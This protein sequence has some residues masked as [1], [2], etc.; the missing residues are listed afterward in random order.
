MKK[1]LTLISIFALSGCE[2]DAWGTKDKNDTDIKK[3]Y[4]TVSEFQTKN[5]KVFG[6]HRIS[7]NVNERGLDHVIYMRVDVI[8]DDPLCPDINSGTIETHKNK[9]WT[10]PL[11]N[12]YNS[13][14]VVYWAI[15]D[16]KRIKFENDFIE[17]IIDEE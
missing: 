2:D 5:T 16:G 6:Y 4:L 11:C 13:A 8:R 15:N 10:W 9:E 1:I 12:G 3:N 17:E 7:I 14:R